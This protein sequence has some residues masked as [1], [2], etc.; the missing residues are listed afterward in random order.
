MCLICIELQKQRMTSHEARR[1][2]AEM[3]PDLE[4]S[5][6][7]EVERRIQD[8]EDRESDD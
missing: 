3:A 1:A 6:A 4:W 2:Y 5:H 8:T 7:R